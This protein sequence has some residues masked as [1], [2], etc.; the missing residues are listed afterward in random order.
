MGKDILEVPP[1]YGFYWNRPLGA[2]EDTYHFIVTP[3]VPPSYRKAVWGVRLPT[4]DALLEQIRKCPSCRE[5][6][7]V[8][9]SNIACKRTWWREICEAIRKHHSQTIRSLQVEI[10]HD[11]SREDGTGLVELLHALAP[12]QYTKVI[13][14]LA[15]AV[16]S[17]DYLH[18]LIASPLSQFRHSLRELRL[19]RSHHHERFV[20]SLAILEQILSNFPYLRV[21]ICH[22]RLVLRSYGTDITC[23]N[24]AQ[25]LLRANHLENV[26]LNVC[27]V[28]TD[29]C[30]KV[31][32]TDR[33]TPSSSP[34]P[35]QTPPNNQRTSIP[36]STLSPIQEGHP[37]LDFTLQSHFF[38][39]TYLERNKTT[40]K[41]A[42]QRNRK[43]QSSSNEEEILDSALHVV[44]EWFTT[45]HKLESNHNEAS[46]S[47][48][49]PA[50]IVQTRP[51]SR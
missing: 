40:K 2:R 23:G 33:S 13:T 17:P 25:T 32:Y 11:C 21:F 28:P 45:K 51:K 26:E 5:L 10:L 3:S 36:S 49:P 14:K 6:R 47:P 41:I 48:A 31:N 39:R 35:M 12:A 24:V 4:K 34:C 27:I 42:F 37:V 50:T 9:E 1:C 15:F 8:L 7:V 44:M 20:L 16:S 18:R 43:V 19:L 29:S 30:P 46:C 38:R 22:P